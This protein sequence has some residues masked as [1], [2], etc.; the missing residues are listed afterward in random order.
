MGI[1]FLMQLFFLGG[2]SR[3]WAM[4][5][6]KAYTAEAHPY[7]RHPVTGVVEDAGNNEGIGQ[8]MTESVLNPVA[9]V[10]KD[11]EGRLYVTVRFYLAE[12]ISNVKFWTQE[13]TATDWSQVSSA[14]TQENLGGEYCT[15]YRLEIP[16]EDAV[17]KSSFFVAPMG[18]DVIFYMDF[19]GLSEGSGD[20][21]VSAGG[22]TEEVADGTVAEEAEPASARA[23]IETAQGLTLPEEDGLK[24]E[25]EKIE[26]DKT[27]KDVLLPA[28]PWELVWQCILIVTLP[29][30]MVGA[31]LMGLRILLERRKERE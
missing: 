11:A 4:E 31:G 20:F 17:V 1:L 26:V 29:G 9:L 7:Y 27:E 23:L 14:I 13:R 22:D 24:T 3:A 15:D 16:A 25:V 28:L 5:S 21:V 10:E 6:G 19:S 12:Y 18:R 8:G 30:L 2:I